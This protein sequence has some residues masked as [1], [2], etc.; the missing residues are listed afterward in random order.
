MRRGVLVLAIAS[1]AASAGA[2]LARPPVVVELYTA[3]GCV[4]CA[5]ADARI[6]SLADAKDVIALTFSVDY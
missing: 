4:S 6:A 2:A 5:A 1:L 3:Q